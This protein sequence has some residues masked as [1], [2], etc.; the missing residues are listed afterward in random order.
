[1]NLFGAGFTPGDPYTLSVIID[2]LESFVVLKNPT[3]PHDLTV[4]ANGTFTE[5][6]IAA[7]G[8]RGERTLPAGMY[9]LIATDASNNTASTILILEKTVTVALDEMNSSGQTGTATLKSRGGDTTT[10]VVEVT[11]GISELNHIHTGQCGTDTLLGVAYGL[12]NTNGGATTTVV[13]ASLAS[14]QDGN[15][16]I[17]LH[18]MGNPGN[19][20]SCGNIS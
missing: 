10:V 17:N 14:L 7:V 4:T 11:G 18:E 8:R 5:T 3:D 19:Y 20:T 6:W 9:T 1:M 16:A 12:T 13:S 2:G 15:H